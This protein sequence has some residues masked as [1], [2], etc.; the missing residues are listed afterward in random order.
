MAVFYWVGGY[1]GYTGPES[2][3]NTTGSYWTNY[4]TGLTTSY[5]DVFYSP[6]AWD[7]RQN[8][9]LEHTGQQ[10]P[11]DPEIRVIRDSV[12]TRLPKGGDDVII[13]GVAAYI[14]TGPYGG[15]S[16]SSGGASGGG[17][18]QFLS[19]PL[20][21]TPNIAPNNFSLLFG[22]MSGDGITSAG[23]TAWKE[24]GST[25]LASFT[26]K[27]YFTRLDKTI[28]FGA[29][30]S[31][32][33]IRTGEIG[34]WGL[35][36]LWGNS[37]PSD[38]TGAAL[39]RALTLVS[40]PINLILAD[41]NN[42]CFVNRLQSSR[43]ATGGAVIHIK[44]MNY[45]AGFTSVSFD[46]HGRFGAGYTAS[47]W[48]T[49]ETSAINH[50]L[51]PRGEWDRVLNDCANTEMSNVVC[52]FVRHGGFS[53][54]RATGYF[55]SDRT[56]NINEFFISSTTINGSNNKTG[57]NIECY[58]QAA[59]G[60]IL[61]IGWRNQSP[62]NCMTIGNLGGIPSTVNQLLTVYTGIGISGNP[63]FDYQFPLNAW[64]E[65]YPW[66]ISNWWTGPIVMIRNCFVE[67]LIHRGG[68]ILADPNSSANDYVILKDGFMDYPAQIICKNFENPQWKNFLL[69]YSP[70]SDLGIGVRTRNISSSYL[71]TY[72][73]RY[74]MIPYDGQGTT[75]TRD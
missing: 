3:Y 10:Q 25:K 39:G 53:W 4:V 37:V 33:S 54:D 2:G 60:K 1:T 41:T 24:G 74:F 65:S 27:P 18:G 73:K 69:G 38:F 35:S 19:S 56:A 67:N 23:L 46:M 29:S 72:A 12:P 50:Y 44:S 75:I 55:S 34:S 21:F 68:V 47:V 57:V 15:G 43:S 42:N 11:T 32:I 71:N 36:Y 30:G 40:N 48:G 17:S 9:R 31:S 64:K 49:N 7:I 52:N 20:I 8:W 22:G 62:T 5:G 58:E 26:V 66:S 61:A 16:T 63:Y 28:N 59:V 14:G 13:G 45:D 6:Y 51:V 70:N